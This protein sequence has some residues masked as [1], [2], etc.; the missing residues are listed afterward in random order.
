MS[1][2]MGSLSEGMDIVVKTHSARDRMELLHH[3]LHPVRS[4]LMKTLWL[5]LGK[6]WI[7]H[8]TPRGGEDSGSHS[9]FGTHWTTFETKVLQKGEDCYKQ[10]KYLKTRGN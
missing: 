1:L 5:G 3:S 8:L 10:F 9:H 4:E 7:L 6:C 2:T